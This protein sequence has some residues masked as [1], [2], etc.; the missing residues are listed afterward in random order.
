[1]ARFAAVGVAIGLVVA[2][3][4]MSSAAQ[5]R[6]GVGMEGWVADTN[7]FPIEGAMVEVWDLNP[8]FPGNP[9]CNS[10]GELDD[11]VYGIFDW[12]EPPEQVTYTDSEGLFTEMLNIDGQWIVRA[13]AEG[14][15][16]AWF[17]SLITGE[18]IGCFT[19]PNHNHYVGQVMLESE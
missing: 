16:T 14:Y 1:M 12:D 8:Y 7:G 10:D 17:P 19:T 3:G 13:S 15:E 18:P 5:A 11:W 4:A 9:T 2:A 6:H